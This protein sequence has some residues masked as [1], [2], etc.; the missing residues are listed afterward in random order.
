MGNKKSNYSKEEFLSFWGV[1]GY[2]ETWDG[3][4]NNWATQIQDLILNEIGHSQNKDVLEIG[5]GGGYWTK[6]LCE[7]SNKVYAIDLLP[8]APLDSH[9]LIYIENDNMQFDCKS[10]EDNSIDFAFSFGTFC[11]LSKSAC[12]SY[13]KDTLRVLKKGST[14]I[15]MYSDDSS[16]KKFFED[17][18]IV[19]SSIYGEYNDYSNIL[20]MIEQYDSQCK[21]LIDFKD[22][23]VLITKR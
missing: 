1:S 20:P 16:L 10:I 9:N 14:A 17:D 6:F 5:C 23:L 19:A 2:V 7:K 21:K 4:K 15:F 12:E 22:L 3:F 11:H 13:L 8:K 18:N